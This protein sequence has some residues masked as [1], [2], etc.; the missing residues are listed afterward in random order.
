MNSLRERSALNASSLQMNLRSW[1]P[2]RVK[3][4]HGPGTASYFNSQ[5][6]VLDVS[7]SQLLKTKTQSLIQLLLVDTTHPPVLAFTD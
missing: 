4:L 6:F 2:V 7:F 5:V 3:G 1:G